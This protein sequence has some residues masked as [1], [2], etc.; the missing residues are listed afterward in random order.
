MG[1]LRR[2]PLRPP[3]SSC[4]AQPA[5][6]RVPVQVPDPRA[7]RGLLGR[8]IVLCGAERARRPPHPCPTGESPCKS[9][10][11]RC[12]SIYLSPGPRARSV[13]RPTWLFRCSRPGMTLST[14]SLIDLAEKGATCRPG[15]LSERSGCSRRQDAA[16]RLHARL[17]GVS[18]H[19]G[20]DHF[21]R[22][23]SSVEAK[24]ADA[25]RKSSLT[26]SSR[27]SCTDRDPQVVLR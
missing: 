1:R 23:S 15:R 11:S 3:G 17:D 4:H 6:P 14:A 25:V 19:V 16:D 9:R 26:R 2:Q 21:S 10:P 24:Y 22:P 7:G 13:R 27:S 12:R 18:V 20:E 5:A 8:A